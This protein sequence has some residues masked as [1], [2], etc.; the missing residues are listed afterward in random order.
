MPA[1]DA[2][3]SYVPFRLDRTVLADPVA[4]GRAVLGI[5]GQAWRLQV[6]RPPRRRSVCFKEWFPD[7]GQT[8]RIS[9]VGCK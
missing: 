8:I 4:P 2:L 5:R 1:F 7:K 3:T 6:H 9:L